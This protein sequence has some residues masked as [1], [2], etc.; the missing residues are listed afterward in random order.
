[1]I[2]EGTRVATVSQSDSVYTATKRMKEHRMNSVIITGN[3]NKPQGIFTLVQSCHY[4]PINRLYLS[5]F[6]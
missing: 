6:M 2:T 3:N 4:H 1:L 5:C